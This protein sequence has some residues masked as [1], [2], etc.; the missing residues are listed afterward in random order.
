MNDGEV[1]IAI[2]GTDTLTMLANGKG[3]GGIIDLNTDVSNIV[4]H[5][6]S[7]NTNSPVTTPNGKFPTSVTINDMGNMGVDTNL[8]ITVALGRDGGC[9]V[10]ERRPHHQRHYA[11]KSARRGHH[12]ADRGEGGP[13]DDPMTFPAVAALS[14]RLAATGGQVLSIDVMGTDM[15]PEI[16]IAN[17]ID[18]TAATGIAPAA[19]L[20]IRTANLAATTVSGDIR[21][22][23]TGGMFT[24]GAGVAGGPSGVSIT[25][26]SVGDDIRIR[27]TSPLATTAAVENTGGGSI[28]L[29]AEGG[30]VAD[31]LSI[32][33]NVATAGGNGNINLFGHSISYT[34]GTVSAS[35]TGTTTVRAGTDTVAGNLNSAG[36]LTG[37]V[38]S[39]ATIS[40]A[41]GTVDIDAPDDVNL[42]TVSTAGTA[43]VTADSDSFAAGAITDNLAS[44][45]A[46]LAGGTANLS[47]ATAI[48]AAG[49]VA[50]IETALTTLNAVVTGAGDVFVNEIGGA[51]TLGN[52]APANGNV[53]ASTT[54]GNL[55]LTNVSGKTVS[56]TSSSSILSAG[57]NVVADDGTGPGT[58]TLNMTASGGNIGTAIAPINTNAGTF[59]LSAD[60]DIFVKDAGDFRHQRGGEPQP[61]R[62]NRANG[63]L[64]ADRRSLLRQGISR[65][66]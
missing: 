31:V 29:A 60:G 2:P 45:A 12:R 4:I 32:G 62:R 5:D 56:L 43:N 37:D 17:N 25:A 3:L 10:G 33:A 1:D 24:I 14:V 57:S 53:T 63:Q 35:G 36:D 55:I 39:T 30:M 16:I 34:G 58:G 38:T 51:V 7:G 18:L 13:S 19:E 22:V 20:E 11:P 26:G 48:G 65:A 50:D 44:E 28:T 52:V 46:N 27:A 9:V 6:F 49:A 64:L 21:I 54:S 23:D 15:N 61:D 66:A 59:N 41:S 42:G 40:S 47:A 8:A